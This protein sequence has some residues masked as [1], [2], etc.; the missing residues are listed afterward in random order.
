MKWPA[1]E[2]A[3]VLEKDGHKRSNIFRRFFGGAL[4]CSL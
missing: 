3:E 4:Y 2:L 1:L